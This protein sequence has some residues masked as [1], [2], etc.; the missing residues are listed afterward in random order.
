ML[1]HLSYDQIKI[2]GNSVGV[3]SGVVWVNLFAV[4]FFTNV[5]F[6][7]ILVS[8]GSAFFVQKPKYRS[9]YRLF[10]LLVVTDKRKVFMVQIFFF[11][12]GRF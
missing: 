5:P 7:V 3:S 10:L 2:T 12:R 11:L 6:D 4:F 1:F 9:S 8:Y